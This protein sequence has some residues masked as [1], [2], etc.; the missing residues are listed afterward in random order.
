VPSVV[1]NRIGGVALVAA[2]AHAQRA[3]IQNDLT[4]HRQQRRSPEPFVRVGTAASLHEASSGQTEEDNVA[5]TWDDDDRYWKTA[6]TNRP[7]AAGAD[8]DTLQPGYRYGY[9]SANRYRGRNW[10][11]VESDLER[12]WSGY[13]HRGRST[14]QQVKDAVRDGWDRV[15]GRD[16][17]AVHR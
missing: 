15:M 2:F 7:Y 8:Y 11:D 12:G 10:T 1:G 6:W 5:D 17:H 14:W 16:T 4:A 9:E 13:E 3:P